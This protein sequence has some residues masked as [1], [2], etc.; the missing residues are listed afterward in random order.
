[1]Y[2]DVYS[3][4][5]PDHRFFFGTWRSHQKNGSYSAIFHKEPTFYDQSYTNGLCQNGHRDETSDHHSIC[6]VFLGQVLGTFLLC[7]GP[8]KKRNQERPNHILE[9]HQS[10]NWKFTVEVP[11]KENASILYIGHS[12]FPTLPIRCRTEYV[13]Q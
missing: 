11:Q 9:D 8:T 12:V 3:L 4:S 5:T 6:C 7:T 1:M 10:L 13:E 2:I